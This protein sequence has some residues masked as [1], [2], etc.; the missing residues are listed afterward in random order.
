M[1]PTQEAFMATFL[2]VIKILG[3]MALGAFVI[4]VIAVLV[5]V[6]LFYSSSDNP[7]R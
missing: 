2:L 1:T 3:Y 7:F 5:L 4:G 6:W